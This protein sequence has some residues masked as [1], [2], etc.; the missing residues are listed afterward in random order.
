MFWCRRP[1]VEDK[2]I[3]SVVEVDSDR[4]RVFVVEVVRSV[5]RTCP[6]SPRLDQIC[7]QDMLHFWR[8]SLVVWRGGRSAAMC[9]S[10]RF[11]SAGV[12]RSELSV[13]SRRRLQ[14][15]CQARVTSPF[16]GWFIRWSSLWICC[17]PSTSTEARPELSKNP[18]SHSDGPHLC[19]LCRQGEKPLPTPPAHQSHPLY[20]PNLGGRER[21]HPNL[22]E[23]IFTA[24]AACRNP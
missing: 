21:D 15:C 9:R 17:R 14:C 13:G 6:G 20:H 11:R 24:C 5:G 2:S 1:G 12:T 3:S 16:P 18:P 22:G 10:T 23:R 8:S 19:A 4:D 7:W